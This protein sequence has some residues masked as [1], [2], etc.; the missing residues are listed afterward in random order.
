MSVKFCCAWNGYCYSFS[1]AIHPT[2]SEKK[3]KMYNS[4][5]LRPGSKS[6]CDFYAIFSKT[7][8]KDILQK[9]IDCK[10]KKKHLKKE[11]QI[12]RS[13]DRPRPLL[14]DNCSQQFPPH[15]KRVAPVSLYQNFDPTKCLRNQPRMVK[16]FTIWRCSWG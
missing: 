1:I 7:I 3:N 16:I 4:S 15:A 11:V 9:I 10:V 12:T 13:R 5:S 6:I 8:V 14:S 2:V